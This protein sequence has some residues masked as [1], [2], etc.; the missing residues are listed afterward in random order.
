M[1]PPDDAAEVARTC[2]GCDAPGPQR[3]L[4]SAPAV[5]VELQAT[6]FT[7]APY[8]VFECGI[9]GLLFKHPAADEQTLQSYYALSDYRKWEQPQY[10]PTERLALRTLAGLPAGSKILDFG[11]S[12]GRLLAGLNGKHQCFGLE[13]NQEAARQAAGKGIVM[14]AGL[15]SGDD[16]AAPEYFDAILLMDVFEHL[17][18][19]TAMLTKLIARL[20]PGGLLVLATG[21]GDGAVCRREPAQ[22]WY[23]RTIEHLCMLT[24]KYAKCLSAG[25]GLRILSWTT[26][27]HYDASWREWL[28]QHARQFAYWSFHGPSPSVWRFVWRFMPYLRLARNWSTP[29][30]FVLSKDHIVAVLQ[31]SPQP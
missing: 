18:A 25:A 17:A 16:A 28:F 21:D 7:Q 4:G 27:S 3:D 29:P 20:A 2:P 31:K 5:V 12:S 22:F 26:T 10:Y 30:Y 15:E 11:C 23:F 14:L 13:P 1:T 9:C 19:P 6:A 24:R 8:R